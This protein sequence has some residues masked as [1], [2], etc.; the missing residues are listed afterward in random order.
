LISASIAKPSALP[1]CAEKPG[2]KP[3]VY[4][5]LQGSVKA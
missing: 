2:A 1:H 5:S 4:L 3:E